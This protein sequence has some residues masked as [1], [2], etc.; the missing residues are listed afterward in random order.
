MAMP[1]LGVSSL[2]ITDESGNAI[3]VIS[4]T[5]L[6]MALGDETFSGGFS[7]GEG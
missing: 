5:D 6:V 3:T 4:A 7:D 2:T 1:W